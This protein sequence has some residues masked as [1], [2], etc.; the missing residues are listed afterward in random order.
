MTD[1]RGR[2]GYQRA[3][4]F[5]SGTD[6]LSSMGAL[7]LLLGREARSVPPALRGRILDGVARTAA[8]SPA[9]SD[10]YRDFFLHSALEAFPAG[11]HGPWLG[12]ARRVLAAAQVAEGPHR[13]SW[14]PSDSWGPAGGR[15][16][17]TAIGALILDARGRGRRLEEWTARS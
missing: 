10:L 1:D 4:E 5:Q 2:V 13:G 7:C 11:R 3:G 16:Y 14:E 6:A 12:E 8:R 9:G 17:S 15:V